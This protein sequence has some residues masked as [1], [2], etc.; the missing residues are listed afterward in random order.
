MMN[1]FWFILYNGIIYPII[2]IAAFFFSIFSAKMR[3]GLVG[4]FQ[5][6]NK[7]KNYLNNNDIK[8]DIYWFHVASLG[9]F[10][11]IKPILEGLKKDKKYNV[12]FVSFS[13][14]SGMNHA[15]SDAIDLK[16]YSPF[17]FPWSIQKVLRLVKPKKIIFSTYDVWPNFLWISK[18]EKIN[19]SIIS[20]KIEK[21]SIKFKPGLLNFYKMIYRLFDTIYTITKEDEKRFRKII[22][23]QKKPIISSLG[24]PRFDTIY[25]N[26]KELLDHNLPLL[27][28]KQIIIIGSSHSKDDY[29]LI[30]A[31]SNLIINFPKLRIIHAPH[32][33]SKKEIKKIQNSYLKF[34]YDSVVLNDIDSVQF[35]SDQIVI[36]GKVGFLANLYWSSV[37]TYIGG[38]FSTGIH[39]VM[40]PAIASNPVIFGPKYQKFNEAEQI[41]KLGGGFCVHDSKS[42]EKI[43]S[44]LL[45][46]SNLLKKAGNAS[47]NLI[48]NNIGSSDKVINGIILD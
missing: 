30:P 40:E 36:I 2:I 12:N 34:G 21:H 39:N 25:N 23:S 26:A 35:S 3:E 13:S 32:E 31:L 17:D 42:I 22:G 47:L 4:R 11:Q 44:K 29:H 5:T 37:I 27:E 10:Y 1:I 43:F 18:V 6:I 7:L 16:F 15:I 9:E 20:A 14:P 38:G 41:L 19:L 48:T 46:S 8:D 45:K 28:R 33:P 24:N